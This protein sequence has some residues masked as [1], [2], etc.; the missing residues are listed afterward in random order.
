MF[1]WDEKDKRWVALHH[2]FTAP[3]CSPEELVA[4]PG[5]ALSIAYDM[6]LNGTELGGGSVRIHRPEMQSAVLAL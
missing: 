2:P 5:K 6:V 4:N 3:K 1:E